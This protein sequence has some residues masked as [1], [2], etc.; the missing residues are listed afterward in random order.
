MKRNGME[1]RTMAVP[2]KEGR[3]YRGY[4]ISLLPCS[5]LWPRFT[6]RTRQPDHYKPLKHRYSSA[7]RSKRTIIAGQTRDY[8]A[9]LLMS[10]S[11]PYASASVR[12]YAS[13]I[14]YTAHSWWKRYSGLV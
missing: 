2:T 4:S 8:A 5:T 13:G 12:R 14:D 7:A 6:I 10:L 1:Y 3:V 9:T 11:F